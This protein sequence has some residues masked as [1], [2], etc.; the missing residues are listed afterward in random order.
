[1]EQMK[2][3][4]KPL[5]RISFEDRKIIQKMMEKHVPIA[6]IADTVGVHK[7]S[8]YNELR[9]CPADNYD[10]EQAQLSLR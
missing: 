6:V 8:I 2:K 7:N 5:K 4:R 3:I 10:A 1:M 9:R